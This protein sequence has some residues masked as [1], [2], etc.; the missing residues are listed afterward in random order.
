MT[1]IGV[2]MGQPRSIATVFRRSPPYLLVNIQFPEDLRC[3][4]KMLIL[5]DS[6]ITI[7]AFPMPF[8]T[9]SFSLT[10]WHYK[11]VGEG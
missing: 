3:I 9:M 6:A 4:E 7:S 1:P 2:V 5:E 11:P 10:S 8:A